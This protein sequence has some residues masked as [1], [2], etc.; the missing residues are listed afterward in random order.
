MNRFACDFLACLA[1][2]PHRRGDEPMRV[3]DLR[4][5]RNLYSVPH[6]RGDEPT[7]MEPAVAGATLYVFPTGV[8]MNRDLLPDSRPDPSGA[9]VP[10][11]R[12]DEPASIVCSDLGMSKRV[13]HR[14]GDEPVLSLAATSFIVQVFPTGVGMNRHIRRQA[15]QE[16]GVPHRRGD[17]PQEHRALASVLQCSPQAWG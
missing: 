12:G 17:E 11:R 9:C 14:R 8:G 6:R 3:G 7:C 15:G 13:P 10:H 4:Y 16:P 2:V 1:S 5:R